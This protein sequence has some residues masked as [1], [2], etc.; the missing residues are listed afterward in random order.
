MSVL[1]SPT[2]AITQIG[3]LAFSIYKY[4]P[5]ATVESILGD[6]LITTKD[7]DLTGSMKEFQS[8]G[9]AKWLDKTLKWSGLQMMDSFGK[10]TT[11]QA[12]INSAKK[13]SLDQFTEKFG[14]YYGRDTNQTYKDLKDNKN[15]KLTR[16]FAF[17]ELSEMQPVSMSEMPLKYLEAGNGRI[18]YALKSYNIKAINVI[19]RE[20]VH[21]W[22]FSKTPAGKAKA[23]RD[24][25]RLILLMTMAGAT[26]DELKD[27]LLG[28]DAGTF[29]ENVQDNLLKIAMM[30]RYTL[31]Q[32]VSKGLFS[33]LLTD[34]LAPPLGFLDDPVIDLMSI[35]EG[36]PDFKTI[37]NLPWGKI[38]YSWLSGTEEKKDMG[39]LKKEITEEYKEGGSYSSVRKRLNTYNAWA[40]VEKETPLTI[41]SLG[42][43]KRRA[44][45]EERS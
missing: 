5:G 26:A 16:F 29:S 19:Y 2:S 1:S 23:A 21:N 40:R 7:L 24:V 36:E 41:S 45:K 15:T 6:K 32:G 11:M 38:P 27:L 22:R 20:S 43:A 9:T 14:E 42:K 17:N 10:E 35:L 28:K 8:T 31:D 30:S 12:A 4:G 44:L 25:G 39:N 3:D 37:Q 34:T 13:M 33:T 18:M